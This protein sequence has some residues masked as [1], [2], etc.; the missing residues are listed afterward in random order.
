MTAAA[1][2]VYFWEDFAPGSVREFGGLKVDKEAVLRF[3]S[4]FDPQPFHLDEEAAKQS[5]FG[6]LAASGWHTC[7]MVMRMM[8]DNYLLKA[9]SLGSPGIEKLQWLKPVY[10]G[11]VLR[12]RMTVLEARPMNSKPHVGLVRSQWEALATRADGNEEVVLRMEGWGMF[13]RREVSEAA[14]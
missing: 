4:E 6:G 2:P 5:L 7:A 12:V 10:P 14:A 3:A 11:D 1:T 8:C 9:A 13:R